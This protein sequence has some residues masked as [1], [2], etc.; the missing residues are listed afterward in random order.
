MHSMQH[1]TGSSMIPAAAALLR[2][3]WLVKSHGQ[4]QIRC[5]VTCWQPW[6]RYNAHSCLQM[7]GWRRGTG[8]VPHSAAVTRTTVQVHCREQAGA[9]VHSSLHTNSSID[10]WHAGVSKVLQNNPPFLHFLQEAGVS[11]ALIVRPSNHQHH[12]TH[13]CM[14]S[15]DLVCFA[16]ALHSP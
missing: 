4:Q 3:P 7:Q 8:S 1:G 5:L 12:N 13:L 10:T 15:Y 14:S 16:F 11:R 2:V 6:R 9:A